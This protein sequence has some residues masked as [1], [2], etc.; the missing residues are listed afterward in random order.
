MIFLKDTI[1]KCFLSNNK[2]DLRKW[3]IIRNK[4]IGFFLQG[5]RFL[6]KYGVDDMNM[7]KNRVNRVLNWWFRFNRFEMN[8]EEKGWIYAVISLKTG[9]WYIGSTTRNI[10]DRWNE[11]LRDATFVWKQR[12]DRR[13]PLHKAMWR[14]GQW[15]WVIIPLM[16]AESETLI[17]KIENKL[18]EKLKPNL[19]RKVK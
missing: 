6:D 4:L 16:R 1:K 14:I 12:K 13:N 18:I 15:N 3:T 8:W 2:K 17:R 5:G 10:K 11:H 9:D 7:R 19:N